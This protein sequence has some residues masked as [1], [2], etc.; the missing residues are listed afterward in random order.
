MTSS[1]LSRD[2]IFDDSSDSS[3]FSCSPHQPN[4]HYCDRSLAI[5]KGR[6]KP[7][8]SVRGVI[9]GSRLVLYLKEEFW[10]RVRDRRFRKWP[11][12]KR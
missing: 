5:E 9:L 8:L 12:A 10:K 1:M 4:S 11:P 6:A 7:L 2:V 3:L